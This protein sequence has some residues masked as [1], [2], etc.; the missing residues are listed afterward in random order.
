MAQQSSKR[1][2][3][4]IFDGEAAVEDEML[5]TDFQALLTAQR[6]LQARAASLVKSAYCVVGNEFTL[7]SVVFFHFLVSDDGSI[8]A[9]FN[10]PLPY[11]A[12]QA[13]GSCDLGAGEIRKASRGQCPVPWH[14]ANLWEPDS[15]EI[16]QLIQQHIQSN[17]LQ[18]DRVV[19]TGEDDFF[20]STD[21]EAS[22]G[23]E[24][25]PIA[26]FKPAANS[27]MQAS[28]IRNGHQSE[29]DVAQM[30]DRLA[31]VFGKSG[32]LSVQEMIRLHSEQ[33][34]Q[35]RDE[36]RAD[37]EVQQ[38][39]YLDQIRYAQEEVHALKSAL[40]Q[41]KAVTSACSRC[42]GVICKASAG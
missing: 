24:L 26:V 21:G 30:N 36:F 10:L 28:K 35:L 37:F 40:R 9:N 14:A 27:G 4:Y 16:L 2:I 29:L 6:P 13:G 22:G 11:L 7:Q 20:V 39:S 41:D 31:Q 3:V 5:Y 33:L 12:C 18:L 34:D 32:K 38:L 15:H 17:R 8:D 25:T 1:E 42:C 23:I 19:Y